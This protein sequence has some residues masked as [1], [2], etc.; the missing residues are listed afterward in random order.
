MPDPEDIEIPDFR[1]RPRHAQYREI[2]ANETRTIPRSVPG[3]TPEYNDPMRLDELRRVDSD[4][5]REYFIS[6]Y[7]TIPDISINPNERNDAVRIKFLG[8]NSIYITDGTT[9]L[10]IDPF[11]TRPEVNARTVEGLSVPIHSKPRIV[12]A[13]L[14]YAQIRYVD[15]ILMTHAHWDHALDIAEVWRALHPPDSDCPKIYGCDSIYQIARGGA[16]NGVVPDSHIQHP[17]RNQIF[18]IGNFKVCFIPGIQA[19]TPH[20]Q[21]TRSRR[22]SMER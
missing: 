3:Y 18:N 12:E 20:S 22:H 21:R 7:Y 16:Q 10:L 14:D 6:N 17:V 19:D 15:A 9:Q 4:N 5:K 1:I 8:C 13:T 2:P 11:F